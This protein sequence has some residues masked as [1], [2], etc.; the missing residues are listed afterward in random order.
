MYKAQLK[1]RATAGD[2]V[3][4]YNLSASY[5]AGR[6]G[7]PRDYAAS[8]AWAATAARI[9]GHVR[10]MNNVGFAFRHGEGS[11]ADPARAYVE[12][13]VYLDRVQHLGEVD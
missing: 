4:M 13:T 8:L 7:L 5:D 12:L 9:G 2:P 6:F 3:A 11:A 1:R 10:A